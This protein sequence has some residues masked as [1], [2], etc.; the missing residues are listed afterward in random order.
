[1]SAP[2]YKPIATMV[3]CHEDDQ[4]AM[5]TLAEYRLLECELAA[6][7][8]SNERIIRDHNRALQERRFAENMQSQL[9]RENAALRADK[10]RLERENALLRGTVEALGD[11]NDRLTIEV[12]GLRKDKERLDWLLG[13]VNDGMCFEC[14]DRAAIDAARA[15]DTQP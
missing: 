13:Q 7:K 11:G 8:S 4:D 10:E 14:Y 1:V 6:F 15:K 12:T 5:V 2:T 3:T 9:E